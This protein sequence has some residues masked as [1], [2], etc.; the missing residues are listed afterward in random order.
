M[1]VLHI[2]C[3]ALHETK[4]ANQSNIYALPY[5]FFLIFYLYRD[6]EGGRRKRNINVR[7]KYQSVASC[8]RPDQGQN[9][10]PRQ[11]P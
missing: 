5:H 2:K 9:W 3:S 8:M 1:T 4:I 11:V 10:Q 6:K 7:D